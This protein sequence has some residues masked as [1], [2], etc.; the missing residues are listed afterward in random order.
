MNKNLIVSFLLGCIIVLSAGCSSNEPDKSSPARIEK[1]TVDGA[2]AFYYKYDSQGRLTEVSDNM[3]G[4]TFYVNYDPLNIKVTSHGEEETGAYVEIYDIVLNNNK[5]ISKFK[6]RY[7]AGTSGEASIPAQEGSITYDVNGHILE[8]ENFLGDIFKL[9]W[10]KE[11]RLLSSS[12]SAYTTKYTSSDVPNASSQWLPIWYLC[13]GLEATGLIGNPPS[14]LI[15][16]GEEV[17]A[18]GTVSVADFSYTLGAGNLIESILFEADQDP[19][20]LL[21]VHYKK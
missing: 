5:F 11:G 4:Q 9:E 20:I 19:S 7:D 15:S 12:N 1:I 6:S 8:I 2:D 16:H 13:G 21:S 14:Y 10:D 3:I 18:D 17:F